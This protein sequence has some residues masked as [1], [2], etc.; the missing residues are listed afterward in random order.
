[1][2]EK[3]PWEGSQDQRLSGVACIGRIASVDATART[4]R[5]QTVGTPGVSDDMDL[6]DVK[7]LHNAWHAQGDEETFIPRAGSYC[8][9]IFANSQP[10]IIGYVPIAF[11]DG[12]AIPGA[13]DNEENLQTGD[14]TI[15]TIAGNRLTLRAG[16]AVTLESTKNCRT[17]WI[18]SKNLMNSVCENYEL[19]V[20]GGYFFWDTADDETDL[21]EGATRYD[22]FVW[23]NVLNPTKAA[24]IQMG[25][26]EESQ[27]PFRFDLG[28]LTDALELEDIPGIQFQMTELGETHLKIKKSSY[29]QVGPLNPDDSTFYAENIDGENLQASFTTPSGHAVI[30]NDKEGEES[31][32]IIH[33]LGALLQIDKEGKIV[34]QSTGGNVVSFGEE[35]LLFTSK[36]GASVAI[37]DKVAIMDSSGKQIISV[38]DKGIQISGSK[39]VTVTA[40]HVTIAGSTID[41][42]DS[43]SFHAVIYEMLETIFDG[44]MHPTALGPSGPPMP[45]N[46]MSLMSNI[47]PSSAKATNVKIRGN[48]TP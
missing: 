27:V 8:I 46:T 19:E 28:E 34:L 14:K 29:R 45:P 4:C 39:D 26:A 17:Y 41:L 18:P 30:F 5:V 10:Y 3:S 16:G 11:E 6:R 1:M 9:I 22:L 36:S 40:P 12:S 7:I 48:L 13:A 35:D 20:N 47:P 32:T 38:T 25:T 21:D 43:P 42:G 2:R 44:H 33:K 37:T 24:R 23:D 15:A 31:I